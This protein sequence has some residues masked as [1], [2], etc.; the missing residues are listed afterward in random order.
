MRGSHGIERVA[1]LV[2]HFPE[3]SQVF[4]NNQIETLLER[5]I[6]VTILSF[7]SARDALP[8]ASVAQILRRTPVIRLD[9]PRLGWRRWLDLTAVAARPRSAWR[10]VRLA[11]AQ[12]W[13]L[14]PYD[15]TK[16]VLAERG[17]A[18]HRTQYD[19][20]LC[21][22]GPNGLLG[23]AMRDAGLVQGKVATFFHGYDFSERI[24]VKGPAYYQRLFERGDVFVANTNFTRRCLLE[25]G[26][27]GERTATVP[28][29]LF[30]ERLPFR[31]RRG[32]ADRR[33]RFLSVGRLVDKK[34][35]DDALHALRLALD[36]GLSATYSIV[37][38]GPLRPSLERMIA[39]LGLEDAVALLGARTHEEVV[40]LAAESDIFVLAS[41]HGSD[42]DVEGQGLALQEAQAMG[43]PVIA[44]DH[45]GFPEGMIDGVT[46]LLVPEGDPAAL[47]RVM[48]ELGS[49]PERWAPMGRA[50]AAFVRERYDQRRL[51][52]QLIALLAGGTD[53]EAAPRAAADLAGLGDAAPVASP[54]RGDTP[55]RD[56]APIVNGWAR[57][58]SRPLS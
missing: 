33:V 8:H 52:D 27:P 22:F 19:V 42:G 57:A 36:A 26:C 38:E 37:G 31:E 32:A 45:N 6:D 18:G 15:W 58:R 55:P 4:I 40:G 14:G 51:T 43:L 34:G 50:G 53:S 21:H 2:E 3:T 41:K 47:A 49:A 44:T 35:H 30:P 5:G 13:S 46:G 56:H 12:G 23:A 39:G 20:L 7:G 28:V 24:R 9:V 11:R 17:L 1:L 48:T 29:G 10:R 16:L 54:Q 25:L